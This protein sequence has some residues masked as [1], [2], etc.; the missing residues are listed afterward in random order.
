MKTLTRE[1]GP[2][3]PV[4]SEGSAKSFRKFSESECRTMPTIYAFG[5]FR[6]DVQG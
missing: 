3:S 1:F 5:P 4:S 6:L 2:R